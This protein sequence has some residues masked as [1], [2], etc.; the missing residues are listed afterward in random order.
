LLNRI[1]KIHQADG[2]ITELKYDAYD[3]VLQATDK[4]HDVEFEYTELGSLQSRTE[5]GRKVK[6]IYNVE[7]ELD[8]IKNEKGNTY[9]FNRNDT[10]QIIEEIGFDG[11]TRKYLRD[12]AGQVNTVLRPND[13]VTNYKYDN[14]GRIYK[15]EHED[16]NHS[17]F[18]Y[19]KAGNLIE[20]I[21]KDAVV[22][23][24]RD[25]IGRI[26]E[27]T[28][29]GVTVNSK[30][31][32]NGRNQITSSLGADIQLNRNEQTGLVEN[33]KAKH[34][35]TSIWEAQIK[36]DGTGLEIERSLPGAVKNTL[37]RDKTGN[38]IEHKTSKSDQILRQKTYTWDVNNR[39]KSIIDG[40]THG[41]IDFDH[42]SFGNLI[43]STYP[44][45]TELFKTSDEVGN[46]FK[47]KEQSDRIYGDGSKLLQSKEWK[48][49]YD[50]EGNLIEKQHQKNK[51]TWTY[52]W[53][54]NGMLKAVE[55]PDGKTVSFK[56]DAL[57]R[58][59]EKIF[60]DN[61]TRWVWDGNVP[62]HEWTE[63]EEQQNQLIDEAGKLAVAK[64]E[65]IITWVFDEGSFVPAA[66]IE[67]D[68]TYSII[69]D[70]LGTPTEMYNSDGEK[71]WA[72]E[73]DIYGKI[74]NIDV[75]SLNDC[76]F[77]YQ[78]QY[79]DV[80]TGL[81]YNR[82][83]Y[84]SPDEGGYISQDPIRMQG[85]NPNI[86]A[87]VKDS[88]CSFDLFGLS[89]YSGEPPEPGRPTPDNTGGKFEPGKGSGHYRPNSDF[90]NTKGW[91]DKRG[92]LWVPTGTG[93]TAHGGP[94]WDVQTKGGNGYTN[95][96]PGGHQSGG[97]NPKPQLG[98]C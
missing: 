27:E 62:L 93:P 71:T 22:T 86:Y 35:A 70:Y 21:N 91:V 57:G 79:E 3:G 13:A 39:L 64:P 15:V 8:Y 60:E 26:I 69:T 96:Y 83:R 76:T 32:A 12:A 31:N 2:N 48:Y 74:R 54:A 7:E 81:Y 20:A 82:F 85:N 17:I 78:G 56:Y 10:G 87:F 29:N 18:G 37:Q 72:C 16:G 75:G 94:H 50:E 55:R 53:Q 1:T 95:V 23:F 28:Q 84:Y 51:E 89:P 49:K 63:S 25:A 77:R 34:N 36:R 92:N 66:K 42:D 6:F 65:D 19:D 5:K 47:T 67:G 9:R 43:G 68:E 30:Y 73:L 33:V 44:D 45:G 46:L 41:Q 4:H 58:R 52:Q 11:L 24:G 88:N 40:I 59:I 61:S 97:K 14:N 38:V 80:E 90:N 98:G